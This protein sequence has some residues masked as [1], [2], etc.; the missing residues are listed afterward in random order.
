LLRVEATTGC[1]PEQLFDRRWATTLLDR[2]LM[3]LESEWAVGDRK[4]RFEA[5]KIYL[6]GEPDVPAYIDLAEQLGMSTGAIKVAVLRLRQRFREL[7]REEIAHTVALPSQIDD[8]IRHL[9]KVVS[10]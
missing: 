5:L 2:V 7:L 3:R 6:S 10:E 8:E 1:D 9:M 4:E